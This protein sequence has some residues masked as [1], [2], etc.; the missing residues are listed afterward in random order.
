MQNRLIRFNEKFKFNPPSYYY[1]NWMTLEE[2][3]SYA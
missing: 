1:R 2:V 3:I